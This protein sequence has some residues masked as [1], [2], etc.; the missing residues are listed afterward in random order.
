MEH[1]T[2]NTHLK[3]LVLSILIAIALLMIPVTVHAEDPV[4]LDQTPKFCTILEQPN[5]FLCQIIYLAYV[6]GF[7]TE[8][9]GTVVG[10]GPSFPAKFFEQPIDT[11]T[12]CILCDVRLTF[13][14]SPTEC[15]NPRQIS[16]YYDDGFF[17]GYLTDA[18][19]E[20]KFVNN[21]L[22]VYIRWT[23]KDFNKW[24]NPD[25]YRMDLS[26]D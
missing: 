11:Y 13:D 22:R 25:N 16:I 18:L 8:H 7:Q 6:Y 9:G 2:R 23:I 20:W 19:K 21:K 26:C 12:Q 10:P 5:K 14:I 3:N 17:H 24:N 4:N 15:I 1:N